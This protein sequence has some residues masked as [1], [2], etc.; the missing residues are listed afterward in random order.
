MHIRRIYSSAIASAILL[1]NSTPAHADSA[2]FLNSADVGYST[3]TYEIFEASRSGS[4]INLNKLTTFTRSNNERLD[5]SQSW[6]NQ[7]DHKLYFLT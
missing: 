1:I 6:Y 5:D 3:S 7:S 4:S 2:Y